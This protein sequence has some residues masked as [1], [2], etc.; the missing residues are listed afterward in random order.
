MEDTFAIAEEKKEA[1][2]ADL[3]APSP[4]EPRTKWWMD[5]ANRS[6]LRY[7]LTHQMNQLEIEVWRRRH[8]LKLKLP[9][10]L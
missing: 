8:G 7:A 10:C 4:P 5:H 9:G 3:N 1:L 2:D 6:I